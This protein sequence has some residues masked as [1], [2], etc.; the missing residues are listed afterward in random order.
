MCKNILNSKFLNMDIQNFI[1]QVRNGSALPM[2]FENPYAMDTNFVNALLDAG[3]KGILCSIS[4]DSSFDVSTNM[5]KRLDSKAFG[6]MVGNVSC[7]VTS[8]NMRSVVNLSLGSLATLAAN[9]GEGVLVINQPLNA[10]GNKMT[11]KSTGL[12]VYNVNS[13][14]PIA[15]TQEVLDHTVKFITAMLD[16]KSEEIG[17]PANAGKK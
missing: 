4:P 1:S 5:V 6:K 11:S 10:E 2:G 17:A 16:G 14:A 3:T 13:A 15:F 8:G 7:V 9:S 12:P